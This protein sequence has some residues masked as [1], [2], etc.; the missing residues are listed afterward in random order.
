MRIFH[1]SVL[2]LFLLHISL[3]LCISNATPPPEYK[4]L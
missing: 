4:Q 1:P 3:G 2:K